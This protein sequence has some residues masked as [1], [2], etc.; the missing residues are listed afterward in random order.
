MA[1]R[2]NPKR[3][4]TPNE[5]KDA[6]EWPVLPELAFERPFAA[7]GGD[8]CDEFEWRQWNK[9]LYSPADSYDMI[10]VGL[11]YSSLLINDEGCFLFRNQ[12]DEEFTMDANVI[13]L[14]MG[15]PA[16]RGTREQHCPHDKTLAQLYEEVVGA[17]L[18]DPPTKKLVVPKTC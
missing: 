5:F 16:I 11:F 9:F 13:A 7:H 8:F 1:K 18:V 15:M 14:V 3:D 2:G 17:P 10:K 6:S 4:F 12:M